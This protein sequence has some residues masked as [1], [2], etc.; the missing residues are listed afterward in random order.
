MIASILSPGITDSSFSHTVVFVFAIAVF[1]C[2]SLVTNRRSQDDSIDLVAPGASTY[3]PVKIPSAPL[4]QLGGEA[5]VC[6]SSLR[7]KQT[8]RLN[9]KEW[10][11]EE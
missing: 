10:G 5:K 2:P 6:P 3:S 11:W 4:Q 7:S 9:A 1:P 8:C